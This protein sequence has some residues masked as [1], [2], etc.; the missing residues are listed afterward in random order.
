VTTRARTSALSP[1]GRPWLWAIVLL[2]SACSLSPAVVDDGCLGAG[3]SSLFVELPEGKKSVSSVDVS[4]D[5][6]LSS[7]SCLPECDAGNCDCSILATVHVQVG[8]RAVCAVRVI[9]SSGQLFTQ[10]VPF[11]L[12]TGGPCPILD[13]VVA[14][15]RVEFGDASAPDATASDAP[16]D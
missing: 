10:D 4:G 14:N 16:E 8:S 7:E 11:D 1:D 5:C 6:V 13:P 12:V 3:S 9:S 2:L 15:V